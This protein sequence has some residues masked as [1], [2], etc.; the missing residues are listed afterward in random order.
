MY[1][2]KRAVKSKSGFVMM[3]H[4]KIPAIDENLITTVSKK[5]YELCRNS[6]KF[7][8]VIITDDME[9]GA[10]EKNYGRVEAAKMAIQA[11]ATI[12]EY[13]SFER[14]YEVVTNLSG[15]K[16][17]LPL[18]DKNEEI[19]SNVKN[20]FLNNECLVEE[21]VFSNGQKLKD[22]IQSCLIDIRKY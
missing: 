17:L 12:V 15:D 21:S 19:I 20:N 5:A 7:N 22:D 3:A 13:R 6:L 9:M 14:T 11:G 18:I 16:D 10:I 1:P 4:L 8:G 2:F